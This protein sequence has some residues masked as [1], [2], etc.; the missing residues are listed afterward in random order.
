MK[1][2]L[3]QVVIVGAVI[4]IG[5]APQGKEWT[6]DETH[7]VFRPAIR[8]LPPDP[9]YNRLTKV[10]LP[11][12]LPTK[13]EITTE[14]PLVLPI[15]HLSLKEDSLDQAAKLLA[16]SARY[17]AYCSSS[18]ASKKISLEVLGTID[19]LA[20]EIAKTAAVKTVVDHIN[21]EVRFL[22][23]A[24]PISPTFPTEDPNPQPQA[25]NKEVP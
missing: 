12:V 22:A 17:N 16:Q 4:T 13:A 14:R 10:Y 9:V 8:Q 11:E 3:R 7:R 18:I 2:Y 15:I 5:C 1:T 21:R 24:D 20:D 6:A 25:L 19:E 23:L